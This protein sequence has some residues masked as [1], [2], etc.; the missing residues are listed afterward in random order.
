MRRPQLPD[1]AFA[2][3][4]PAAVEREVITTAERLLDKELYPGDPLRLFLE[5]LAYLI[6]LQNAAI[7]LA[8]KQ[9]LLAYAQ[10]AHLDHLGQLMDTAR[11]EAS[12]AITAIRFT[13]A[14]PQ[15]WSVLIPQ[16]SRVTAGSLVFVTDRTAE[17]PPGELFADVPATCEQPGKQGNGLVPGQINKMVDVIGT[18][19]TVANVT[20]TILGADVE[21][22]DP[23]RARIQLAPERFSVAGPRGAYLYHALATHQDIAAVAVF[24]P[25][26]R[27]RLMCGPC[28]PGADCR[29]RISWAWCGNG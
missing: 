21:D 1:V 11:M 17:I 29:T 7:D 20:T 22:D 6:S 5:S 25:T 18:I 19:K 14:E 15:D 23:F 9:N 16:G 24:C 2:E 8:G 4:D 12:K 3:L 27:V 10:G 28:S 13:L 26:S